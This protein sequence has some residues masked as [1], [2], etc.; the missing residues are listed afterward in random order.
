M[1][2]RAAQNARENAVGNVEFHVADLARAEAHGPW[3]G[4]FDAA[5]LDPPRTGAAQLLPALAASGA[6]RILYISCHPGTLARDAGELVRAHGYRLTTAGVF[7][8]FPQTSH[9]E[10][11]ALFELP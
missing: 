8:M 2:A 9:V 11:I 1:V 4:C 10:S 6:R 5:L 7:D 3:H